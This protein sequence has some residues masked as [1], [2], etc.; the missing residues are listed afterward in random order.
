MSKEKFLGKL[1][2]PF[3]LGGV[4]AL[5]PFRDLANQFGKKS[6]MENNMLRHFMCK[7]TGAGMTYK[8]AILN[9]TSATELICSF[10]IDEFWVLFDLTHKSIVFRSFHILKNKNDPSACLQDFMTSCSGGLFWCNR[11]VS[12][13]L[14]HNNYTKWYIE[15]LTNEDRVAL[16]KLWRS[17]RYKECC[18][19]YIEKGS[20]EDEFPYY[21]LFETNPCRA[22]F[23]QQKQY[24]YN[25]LIAKNPNLEIF[26]K[27]QVLLGL[28]K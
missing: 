19:D 9:K 18:A 16:M 26:P 24:V 23:I 6:N 28:Q 21:F 7:K 22:G 20:M 13:P 11:I 1:L 8:R 27:Y 17:T 5:K 3:E 10:P 25:I 4:P 14:C 15:E 2:S 12:N